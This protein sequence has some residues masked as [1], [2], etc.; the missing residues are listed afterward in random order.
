MKSKLIFISIAIIVV[1]GI[2]SMLFSGG[3]GGNEITVYGV[4][5]NI[6][7]GY[8]ESSRANF[9]NGEYVDLSDNGVI[10]EISVSTDS[11]F[12]E[13]QYVTSKFSNTINGKDGTVYT[14]AHSN[15]MSYVYFDQ[16]K[17]I[18]IRGATFS[19]LEEIII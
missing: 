11:H 18:V 2:A 14:Y 19:E 16:G 1:V 4:N 17:R 3:D 6:P 5:F 15:G 10:I 12:K 8:E 9:T 13:S 7:D